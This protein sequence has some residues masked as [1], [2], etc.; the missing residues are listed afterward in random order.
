MRQLKIDPAAAIEIEE[1]ADHYRE[2]QPKL[3]TRFVDDLTYT[4]GMIRQFPGIGPVISKGL[5]V[6]SLAS[7][8]FSLIYTDDLPND[9]VTIQVLAHQSRKPGYWTKRIQ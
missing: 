5:R 7:F 6:R 2:I 3:N 4:I 8:P 9:T 1:A